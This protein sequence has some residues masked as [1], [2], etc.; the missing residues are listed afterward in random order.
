[1]TTTSFYPV[2]ASVLAVA[3]EAHVVVRDNPN[4]DAVAHVDVH[5]N[6]SVVA[7]ASVVARPNHH[8]PPSPP[9]SWPLQ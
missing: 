1:M 7:R 8:A 3:V 5:A 2:K 9:S 6:P 4:V